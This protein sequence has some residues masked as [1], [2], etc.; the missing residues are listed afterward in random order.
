MSECAR[1]SAY[2]SWGGALLTLCLSGFALADNVADCVREKVQSAPAQISIGEIRAQCQAREQARAKA[3]IDRENCLR[4]RAVSAADLDTAGAVRD[5]CDI[6]IAQGRDV[7]EK[8]VATK[9]A[10]AN[11]HVILPYLQ[12][13]ILPYTYNAH[14]NQEAYRSEGN[15][16][17]IESEEVKLQISLRVPLTYNDVLVESDGFYFAFTMKSFWQAYNTAIS[18]PFRETNYRPEIFYQAPLP[19]QWGEGSWQGT[20]GI[21]HESNGRAEELSRS[22][23][24]VYAGLGYLGDRWVF[25]IQPWYRLPESKKSNTDDPTSPFD[26]H[27]DD[28][29]DIL[30]YMGHYEFTGAYRWR[31]LEFSGL[32][33]Q[34][35]ATGKGAQEFGI[36]FPL[37]GRTRGYF[38]YF[39]GYG[40]S[41]IDYNHRNRRVGLGVLLT[42]FL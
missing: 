26:P 23:N 4:E 24:R 3:D 13:Y 38:Q 33:R 1:P 32:F 29:P 22:W 25:G 7:P 8:L 11:R 12:N 17:S 19:I 34:N 28:N 21:S 30:D 9:S 41:L 31:D 16:D 5:Q 36:S 2:R 37:W 6:L 35:F 27:G 20:L 40:E 10:Q 15:V 18:A 39:D 42:D 14:P